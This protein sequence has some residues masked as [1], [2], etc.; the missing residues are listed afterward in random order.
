MR[1][2]V[3]LLVISFLL[4]GTLIAF[5]Q[6]PSPVK[7]IFNGVELASDVPP[8]IINGRVLVPVRVI[9][10]KFGADVEWDPENYTVHI[11]TNR[12]DGEEE[13]EIVFKGGF[14]RPVPGE[15]PEEITAWIDYSR[16]IPCVQEK[17]HNG[18]RYVLVTEGMK[19]TGGYGVEVEEVVEREDKLELVVRSYAPKPGQM[20]TEALTYPY[21]LIILENKELP[22][23][24][25]DV[26]DPDRY[27]MNL[28]DM[29]TIDKPI[30]AGSEWI[31]VFSPAPGEEVAGT[32]NLTGIANVFEGTVS[33]ELL[34]DNGEVLDSGF[35]MAAMGDWAYFRE[36]IP[37]PE[38]AGSGPLTLQLYS[39]SMKDG[40]KMFVVEIPLIVK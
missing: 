8:I 12:A 13:G 19:P 38:E 3:L 30:A 28:I 22:L 39:V 4:L 26:D 32:I 34:A 37:V 23:A 14:Y 21:D 33:Y 31:K 5:A 9:A 10:E 36:E 40:S 25:T 1:K 16:E 15:L 11:V 2:K 6:N 29:E 35:T 17:Y 20:V 18:H 7:I 27:F 24:F